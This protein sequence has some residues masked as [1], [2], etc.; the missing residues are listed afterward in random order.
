MCWYSL[1]FSCRRFTVQWRCTTWTSRRFFRRAHSEQSSPT[2]EPSTSSALNC[3]SN[4]N[5][6]WTNGN[7][8]S[9]NSDGLCVANGNAEGDFVAG[10]AN[11]RVNVF[12]LT[13]TLLAV[14]EYS[15]WKLKLETWA[16]CASSILMSLRWL[17][18]FAEPHNC[19]VMT[20][21]TVTQAFQSLLTSQ[22]VQV[23]WSQS[24]E[25]M[26]GKV[27]T[28]ETLTSTCRLAV[29]AVY[30]LSWTLGASCAQ[31]A[32]M[33]KSTAS[34]AEALLQCALRQAGRHYVH[35]LVIYGMPLYGSYYGNKS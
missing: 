13:W 15:S 1:F 27:S 17:L 24:T 9:R 2:L 16:A 21:L 6:A 8:L 10:N 7:R 11:Q 34:V 31:I 29:K 12:Q 26:P 4:L 5:I 14:A 35:Y 32:H 23:H 19:W 3:L 22:T 18:R 30:S 25:R 20:W 28:S 33:I